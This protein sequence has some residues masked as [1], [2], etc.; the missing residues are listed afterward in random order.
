[1]I[2]EQGRLLGEQ[3]RAIEELRAEVAD[4][5]RRLG[6]NSG[7]SSMPPSSDDLPG[8]VPPKRERRGKGSGRS[9]GKQ[10]GA[11][12]R[13]MTWAK[14]DEVIDHRP[15]GTCGCGADLALAEDLGVAR[16]HQQLEVPLVTARRVQHDLHEARCGCGKVHLADR[17]AGV[18]ASAVSIGPNLRA[19]A[20]CLVVCQHVPVARCAELIADLTGA[21]VSAGFIHSCLA[22]TAGVIADVV[23]LIRTLITAA[24]VAGFDETTLRCGPAG[25]RKYVQA[26]V[27]EL[28]SLFFLGRRTL[29]SFRDFGILPAFA[30]IVVSDWYVNYFHDDWKHVAGN[31]VCL[32]HLIRD[33]EDAAESYPEAVWPARAQRALRGLIAAWHCARDAG[34]PQI[35]PGITAPLLREFRHA[36]LA[37]LPSVPRVPGPKHA[38]AQRPGRDLLEFCRDRPGDVTRF[39]DDTRIWPTNNIS[40]RGVRPLKT[41]QKISGRL[42]SEDT[43]QDRLDI[44]GYT[45]TAR[46][47]G[48]NVMDV[49][50]AAMT[51]NPWHPPDPAPA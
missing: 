11:P 35:P 32:A 21:G 16:S 2:A 36:V 18:P 3:G 42:T 8:K 25:T 45:D 27:T 14:P 51:G 20:V 46:K 44:R 28:Y 43:T 26:A 15:A 7:N 40:E 30:G 6:R 5:R 29:K 50:R 39:C 12:G 10:P 34:Q 17:P 47:H 38:T 1:V 9:R 19:L 4:L 31:Q 49:L 22:R 24:A 13:S 41:Q 23:K 33:Y 48:R 37:G